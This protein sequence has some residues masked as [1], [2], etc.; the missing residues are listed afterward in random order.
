MINDDFPKLKGQ[1]S[2][3]IIPISLYIIF[4]KKELIKY[5]SYIFICTAIIGTIQGYLFYLKN[6]EKNKI[7][8]L[9]IVI[10]HLVLLYPLINI[11]EYLQINYINYL[12][13]IN[14]FIIIKFL[15]YW[16]YLL[17]R[18]SIT[19]ICIIIYL[20][21]TLICLFYTSNNKILN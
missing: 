2:W 13:G 9:T 6:P 5:F 12:L 11:Q 1:L 19:Y 7:V 18:D 20:I 21:L 16:P 4:Y 3:V 15:P 8:N 10:F 17:T 14:G